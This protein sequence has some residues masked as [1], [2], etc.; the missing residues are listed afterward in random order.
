M[1]ARASIACPVCHLSYLLLL[2][3]IVRP[4]FADCASKLERLAVE[5]FHK[6]LFC[7]PSSRTP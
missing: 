2:D 4:I 5:Y 7:R 6:V 1:E 3:E